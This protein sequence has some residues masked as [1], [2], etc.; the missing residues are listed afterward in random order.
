MSASLREPDLNAPVEMSQGQPCSQREVAGAQLGS[1]P[2]C[3]SI[4]AQRQAT[5]SSGIEANGPFFPSP[6]PLTLIS[7][8]PYISPHTQH[9]WQVGGGWGVT[10][11]LFKDQDIL[12]LLRDIKRIFKKIP[13]NGQEELHRARG[14]CEP[15]FGHLI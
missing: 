8:V 1:V 14:L 11:F 3:G 10:F 9:T 12:L 6:C 5:A 2:G 4:L 13:H 15:L 7:P